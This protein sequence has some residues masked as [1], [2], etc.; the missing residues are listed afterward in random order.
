MDGHAC[1]HCGKAFKYLSHYKR[2][3]AAKTP[4]VPAFAGKPQIDIGKHVCRFCGRS[5]NDESSMYRHIRGAC[6]IAPNPKNG[7]KGM[8]RLYAHTLQKH[9]AEMQSELAEQGTK[10]DR[11]ED[12][13]RQLLRNQG[14]APQAGEVAIQGNHA[15]VDN[16]K[17]II[18]I[19]VFGQEKLDHITAERIK[20]ILNECLQ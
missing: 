12:M 20:T 3:L 8:E 15:Q 19:N 4:C 16:S 5:F 7:E 13:M 9:N 14:A 6:K 1:P 17:K 10:I 2:H 11:L 18:N